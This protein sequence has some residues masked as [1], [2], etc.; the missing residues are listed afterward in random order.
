MTESKVSRR[1]FFKHGL[2]QLV[3][4]VREVTNAAWGPEV[5]PESKIKFLRPPGALPEIEFLEKCTRCNECVKVC[6]EESIMK[7]VQDGSKDHLTPILN[8][9]KSACILCED[10][11]CVKVCEPEALVMPES[12]RAVRI[13]TAVINERL[14]HAFQGMDCD[15]CVKECPFPNEA[16]AMDSEGHPQVNIEICTGCGLCEYI[17]PTRQPA[18]VVEKKRSSDGS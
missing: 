4:S 18:I 12:P 2:T 10:F 11:P 6:P 7:F 14:C 13:G 16:I 1:E 8:M 5:P 17:C 3:D 9:R 15:Y